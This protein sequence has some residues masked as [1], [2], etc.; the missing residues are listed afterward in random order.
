MPIVFQKRIYRKDLQKNPDWI[1]VFGD[2]LERKGLGGQA[3]EM[4]GEPNAYGVATKKTPNRNP[5]AYFRDS[6]FYDNVAIINADFEPILQAL[7]DGKTVVFPEDGIGTGL[8]DLPNKAPKTHQYILDI[9][10]QIS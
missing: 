9:L 3:K 4:R 6:E 7:V 10:T 8:S 5:N 2:N 1:Y